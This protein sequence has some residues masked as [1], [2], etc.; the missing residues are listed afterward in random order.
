MRSPYPALVVGPAIVTGDDNWPKEIR[1]VIPEAHGCVITVGVKP[2]PKPMKVGQWLAT[3]GINLTAEDEELFKLIDEEDTES[4][5]KLADFKGRY[6]WLVQTLQ[7]L[8][9]G[10]IAE[11]RLL[12]HRLRRRTWAEDYIAQVSQLAQ[13]SRVELSEAMKHAL[14]QTFLSALE[15]PPPPRPKQKY[16]NLLDS[17]IGGYAWL[18]LI[19]PRDADSARELVGEY[20]IAQFTTEYRAGKLPEKSFAV[21]S[22]ETAKLSAGRIAGTPTRYV[23]VEHEDEEENVISQVVEVLCCPQCGAV[24][25]SKYDPETGAALEPI[26]ASQTEKWID[27]RRRYCK[28][29]LLYFDRKE[30][31]FKRGRW[32]YDPERGKVMPRPHDEDGNPYLCGAPLFENTALRREAAA[33]YILKKLKN[34]FGLLIVDETHKCKAKGTGVGW[35]LQELANATQYTLGLTGT[36]FGGSS[37]SIFWILYRLV[38][39]VRQRFAF[40]DEQRWAAKYGLLKRVFYVSQDA[41]M[42][43]DG[44]FTGTHFFETVEESPG[45]SPTI[46]EVSLPYMA[47]TSLKDVGLPLP[48]YSEEIVRIPLTAAMAEQNARSDGSLED[49]KTGLFRFCVERQKETVWRGIISVW[50]NTALNRPD[51]MFRPEEVWFNQRLSGRGK[52]AIRRRVKITEFEPVIALDD[53]LPKEQWLVDICTAEKLMGRKVLAYVRQTGERD[54]QSRL[55]E[56]LERRGLRAEVMRTNIPPRQRVHWL[57]HRA[58]SVDVMLTNARLVEVGVNLTMFSTGVFFETEWSLVRRTTA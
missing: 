12:I 46:V 11:S 54:I 36:F 52:H 34:F 29:P 43:E 40:N 17:R 25:S 49:P 10:G 9:R 42:T 2:L 23:R 32:S 19:I 22:F 45:I 44:T 16:P 50:L 7:R 56:A 14:Y 38:P 41:M 53:L 3:L 5:L 4:T 6:P 51:A 1:E 33:R 24:V 8:K 26:L 37:T 27:A 55:V 30:Q 21:L 39:E 28:A 15:N 18:G 31:R 20:S 47:A 13:R 57:K 58:E 35:V 48:D